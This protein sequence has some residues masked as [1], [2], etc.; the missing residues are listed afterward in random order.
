MKIK[1]IHIVILLFLVSFAFRLYFSSESEYFFSPE[2]YFHL[3]IID[4]YNEDG[5]I[6]LYDKLSFS[7]K[8]LNYPQFFHIFISFFSFIPYYLKI[9]PALLISSLIIII[10]LICKELTKDGAASVFSAFLTAFLPI[11]L[12]LTI[13]QISPLHLLLPLMFL[14]F[15]CFIKID[16]KKFFALFLFLSFIIPLLHPISIIFVFS[17]VF[18][19]LL[20]NIDNVNVDKR[21]REL[22][23]FT[24][25]LVF[26]IN[27]L[28]FRKAFIFHGFNFPFKDFIKDANT[29]FLSNFNI[30][31]DVFY[32]GALV[33]ILGIIGLFFGYFR[34]KNHNVALFYGFIIAVLILGVLKFIDVNI[35]L[36]L[37]ALNLCVLSS[38]T[39]RKFFDYLKITK[40]SN[41]KNY[42]IYIFIAFITLASVY[43]SFL[44]VKSFNTDNKELNDLKWLNGNSHKDSTVLSVIEEGDLIIGLARRKS[45]LDSDV[46]LISSLDQRIRDVNVIYITWSEAI[47]LDLIKKY[48]INYIYFTK[49]AKDKYKINEILYI[50]DEKCFRKEKETIYRIIC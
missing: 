6:L 27:I 36:L 40:A 37:L 47:A 33:F 4:N 24:F 35:V 39:I 10:Y 21:K 15:Y 34:E 3:R 29:L 17:L 20:L 42:F 9:I 19:I 28:I 48:N 22:I 18:Y 38:F 25:F 8:N 32:L 44:I 5:S 30:F 41:F 1:P 16:N 43:P 45:V 11:E 13:N 31:T 26:F 14:M 12:K 50:K 49:R 46:L 7:G 2:S 23:I